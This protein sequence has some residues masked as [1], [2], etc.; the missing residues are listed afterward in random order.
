MIGVQCVESQPSTLDRFMAV[1]GGMYRYFAVRVGE[2][3]HAADDLMQQLWLEVS[4]NAERTDIMDWEG[5]LR[6]IARNLIRQYWKAR[7]V[8]AKP[9]ALPDVARELANMLDAGPL[10]P[11]MLARREVRDQ[12]LLA[13]TLL[14]SAD[15]ELL[16][17]HHFRGESQ[18]TLALNQNCSE[19]AVEG[20]LYR[21]RRLLRDY[22]SRQ[23]P[24]EAS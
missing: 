23:N 7:R 5:Y 18:R 17:R 4:K 1:S 11:E 9:I 14:S 24:N 12:V 21:A 3:S 19:R 16:V 8:K 20:R 10:P 22:L 6:G 2:D 15:Q 13:L